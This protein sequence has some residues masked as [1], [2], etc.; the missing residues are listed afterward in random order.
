MAP[1]R[2]TFR[3]IFMR[4]RRSDPSRRGVAAVEFAMVVPIFVVF[5]FGMIEFG[6][7]LMV[8]QTLINGSREGARQ[9]VLEGATEDGVVEIVSEYLQAASINVPSDYV[10]VSPDPADVRGNEKITVSISVPFAEVSWMPPFIYD[11]NLQATTTM[12]SEK[13]D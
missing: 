7:I 9:A 5:I 10:S 3:K 12:R 4:R 13:L 8:Q 6:R 2:K 1:A 11:G